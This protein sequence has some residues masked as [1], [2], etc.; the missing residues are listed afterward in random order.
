MTIQDII[1]Q[2]QNIGGS[3][4]LLGQISDTGSIANI[5][6]GE[7]AQAMRN[8]YGLNPVDLPS[9]MFQGATIGKPMLQSALQKTY[10]PQIEAQSQTLLTDLLQKT[11]GKTMRQA[12]GGFA[13]SGQAERFI[14]GA[15]DVYGKG[16]S[17]VLSKVGAQKAQGIKSISDIIQSW[18][19]TAAQLA[20]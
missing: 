9:T 2:L 17:S 7:I 16:M 13:G 18:Q 6:S 4:Q 12:G 10:S 3:S 8:M 1:S 11:G 20:K 19:T 15:R 5:N 14:G